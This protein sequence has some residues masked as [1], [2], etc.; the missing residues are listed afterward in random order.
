[1]VV[2]VIPMAVKLL[3]AAR[4]KVMNLCL[5]LYIPLKPMKIEHPQ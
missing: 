4:V 2:V 1:M 5:V 3:D